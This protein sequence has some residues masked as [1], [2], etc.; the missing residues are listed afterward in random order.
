MDEIG[1]L[2]QPAA[3]IGTQAPGADGKPRQI[4][5]F[6]RCSAYGM[7]KGKGLTRFDDDPVD[8]RAGKAEV[9]FLILLKLHI[10]AIEL[11]QHGRTVPL[12]KRR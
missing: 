12:N 7:P 3:G 2:A 4:A 1:H 9:G 11:P 6:R 5:F 10:Y 8:A